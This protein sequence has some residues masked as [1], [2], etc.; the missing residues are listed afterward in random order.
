MWRLLWP[1]ADPGA[2]RSGRFQYGLR[3]CGLSRFYAPAVGASARQPGGPPTHIHAPLPPTKAKGPSPC[4]RTGTAKE[5]AAR[6][7]LPYFTPHSTKYSTK[8]PRGIVP[9]Y[10]FAGCFY[11][12]VR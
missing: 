12:V 3:C 2:A 6:Q 1:P 4:W 10:N 5:R 9:L 8:T 7:K 11:Y